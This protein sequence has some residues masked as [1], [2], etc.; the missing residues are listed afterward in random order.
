M[1]NKEIFDLIVSMGEVTLVN[2][3]EIS[4]T[5]ETMDRAAETFGVKEFD[6]FIIANGIFTSAVLDGQVYSSK[7][8]CVP[9]SPIYLCRV[10][11]VNNLS[12]EIVKGN[13]SPEDAR[14]QLN[15]IKT[16]TVVNNK[17]KLLASGIGS[18]CFCYLFGGSPL[19][20]LVSFGAGIL[21]YIFLLY[22]VPKISLP[23]IMINI[24]GS[25]LVTFYS[26]MVFTLGVGNNLD[27]II[28]GS[29]ICLVPGVP[30]TNAIRNFFDDDYLSG[31]IRLMDAFL[32]AICIAT[33]VGLV[34]GLWSS[35]IG[36]GVV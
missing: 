22:V 26:C 8:L 12:R 1:T 4:R 28:I 34:L 2:G 21:L 17:A 20:S 35:F 18:A 14:E 31:M 16:L 6:A 36:K 32:V 27:H 11:A 13:A 23:K 3:G 19:D 15:E 10:E 5:K 25:A 24:L 29:I 33:G 9:L 7:I 30:L